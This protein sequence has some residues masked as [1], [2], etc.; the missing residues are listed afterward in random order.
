VKG[1]HKDNVH[2]G[3]DSEVATLAERSRSGRRS[4]TDG[5]LAL[6][7]ELY[8]HWPTKVLAQRLRRST[9]TIY[10]R[11]RLLGVRKSAEYLTSPQAC[12][13]RRGDK[14]GVE[15]R[16]K[17]GHVPANK[18]LRRPGWWAGRMRETQFKKGQFPINKDPGFYVLGALR[19]NADGY[20]DMRVSFEQGAR[21][22]RALH[23]ILWEDQ[24][25][26]VP[27]G[28]ALC[29]K[30]R[31]KLNVELDNLELVSRAELCRRNTIHNL[32]PELKGAIHA[33][34]QLKRRIQERMRP[35]EKQ[36][37]RSA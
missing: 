6:M 24:H 3:L 14:V 2:C 4:W 23:R 36:D 35:R 32:P 26:S 13:L 15:H 22:W 37:R 33:L 27:K 1:E 9:A 17:K 16:F 19:V 7:R 10:H 30:D 21:G 34:G 12:R 25:G 20:I 28:Y 31:D 11:A 5:D 8:P 29:F 18:G